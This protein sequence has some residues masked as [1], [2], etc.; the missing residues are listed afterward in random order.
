MKRSISVIIPA[1]NEEGNLKGA[2]DS[3]LAAVQGFT[4][5][6]IIIF[7]DGSQDGTGPLADEI[8]ASDAAGRIKVVHN[9]SNKG[10]GYNFRRGVELAT[11][12][13]VAMIPGDDEIGK[14][15]VAAILNAAGKADIVAAYTINFSVRPLKRRIISRVFTA[16]MNLLFGMRLKY[17]NGP[18]VYRRDVIQSIPVTTS[19]FAFTA[20]IMVRLIRSGHSYVHVGM[21]LKPRDYGSS[22]AFALSNILSVFKTVIR[23]FWQVHVS[24]RGRYSNKWDPNKQTT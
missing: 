15:S 10:F 13:Y 8:A 1:Y 5:Y 20:S 22:K 14:E 21:Y 7:D 4:D 11:R 23:L 18:T 2:V 3:V 16:M 17:F 19:G 12:D 6:E 9:G 24:E